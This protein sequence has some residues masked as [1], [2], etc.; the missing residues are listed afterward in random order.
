MKVRSAQSGR[1][2]DADAGKKR[3]SS[4]FMRLYEMEVR[5]TTVIEPK[6]QIKSCRKKWCSACTE[7]GMLCAS[8]NKPGTVVKIHVPHPIIINYG[9]SCTFR[10]QQPPMR[11]RHNRW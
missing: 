10:F 3:T 6:I 1:S 8:N 7:T 11:M 2:Q 4:C 5:S 9:S